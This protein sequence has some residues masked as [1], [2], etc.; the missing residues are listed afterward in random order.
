MHRGGRD[1]KA[2]ATTWMGSETR[3]WGLELFTGLTIE[4]IVEWWE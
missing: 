3:F 1:W 2:D 4:T